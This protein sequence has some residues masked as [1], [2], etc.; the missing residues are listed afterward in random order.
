MGSTRVAPDALGVSPAVR[1]GLGL[2]WGPGRGGRQHVSPSAA[3]CAPCPRGGRRARRSCCLTRGGGIGVWGLSDPRAPAPAWFLHRRQQTPSEEPHCPRQ[4]AEKRREPYPGSLLTNPDRPR[5]GSTEPAPARR[6][7]PRLRQG[8]LE[9]PGLGDGGG[10]RRGSCSRPALSTARDPGGIPSRPFLVTHKTCPVVSRLLDLP[11]TSPGPG[12]TIAGHRGRAARALRLLPC[13]AFAR[14]GGAATS[15]IDCGD[16]PH[17]RSSEH[18]THTT[19]G[20]RGDRAAVPSRPP[21]V[22]PASGSGLNPADRGDAAVS[23][24]L[25]SLSATSNFVTLT[26]KRE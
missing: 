11:V 23:F 1:R 24:Q 14:G 6:L 2:C 15:R 10:H 18:S 9:R 12:S 25:W 21:S 20:P 26:Q 13:A 16:F 17:S 7:G 19:Q 3:W 5:G 8:Q 4:P 22:P